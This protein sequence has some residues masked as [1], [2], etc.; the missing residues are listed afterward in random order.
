MQTQKTET[1]TPLVTWEEEIATQ[2]L[3]EWDRGRQYVSELDDLY[4]DIYAMLRGERPEKNYDWQSNIVINKVFQVV[5][6]AIPYI[7]QKIFGATPVIG[8]KSFDKEGAWQREQILEF[9][10]TL[11]PGTDS[12]YVPF[13]LT[14]VLLLLRG[15]LNGVSIMKKSWHQKLK[16]KTQEEQTVIPMEMDAEG[17]ATQVEPHTTTKRETFPI[18]DWPYN[19]VINNKDIVFDW[20][21][22]PSQ[23]IRQGRFIT[24]RSM[25]D[26]DSLHNSKI[27]Y[28][29]LDDINPTIN[30]TDSTISQ[31]HSQVTS[32]DGQETP[33]ES[34]IYVDVETY[35]RQGK[36]PVYKD[37]ESG[38]WKACLDKKKMFDNDVVYKE[39]IA[40]VAKLAGTDEKNNVLIRFDPNP[41]GE[42]LY[43]DLHIYLD[44]ERWNSMGEIEPIKDLQTA[45]N[46]NI[47]AMFDEIWAN[48]APPVVVN[49]FAL[50]DWDTMVYAP[51]QRW[52]VGGNPSDSIYF[53]EPS[54][55][56][57]DAWQKH[58]LLDNEI[59]LGSVTNAMKGAGKE[60]TA[61]TNVMN[62]QM[63]SGKLDFLI[64]MIETT[65]LIPSAQ[66]DVRLAKKFAHPLTFKTILGKDF[67]YSEYEEIYQYTPAASSVK[68]EHQK[69]QETQEDIQLLQLLAGVQNPNTPKVMNVI[70]A[71]ILRNRDMPEAAELF[72]ESFFEAKS[73][74]GNLQMLN[75]MMGDSPSNQS[76]VPMSGQEKSTRQ[77]TFKP[78][79]VK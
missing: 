8:V 26:L 73:D 41:A 12:P 25:V 79:V 2:V 46:D 16:V 49:K 40:T 19:L 34:D 21:L 36:F 37:K 67:S 74:A 68:L 43:I 51:Q 11:Q 13:F 30:T 44:A 57:R 48:L 56:T 18:E 31:D 38:H 53:K 28:M 47:N 14:T 65:A 3:D 35:E 20:L 29:N 5:W 24:H 52:L 32:R 23:S 77:S 4:D 10:H 59:Q 15:M 1:K 70:M 58:M 17:N 45:I 72:D 9:W 75:K 76:G 54:N 69:A 78:R 27:K 22:Q 7:T 55:I 60:K 6:T 50:W 63:T 42:K 71:N 39:M 62:A 66:M 64:K 33:P 61:T